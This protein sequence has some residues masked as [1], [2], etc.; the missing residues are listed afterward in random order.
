MH[1]DILLS[2]FFELLEKRRITA[3]ELSQKHGVSPRTVYR[4]VDRLSEFL[5][6]FILRGRTGGICLADNFKLPLG[7]FTAEE[8]AAAVDGLALAY[9]HIPTSAL[10]SAKRKLGA[11]EKRLRRQ[12]IWTGTKEILFLPSDDDFA[13]KLRAARD[14]IKDKRLLKL[15]YR[16]DGK[17]VEYTVEPHALVLQKEWH[18]FSFCYLHRCF[19]AFPLQ[20]IEGILRT[21]ERFRP[22][23]FDENEVIMTV[24]GVR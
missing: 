13:E 21:R 5:P 12:R 14:C 24:A 2:I 3:K 19:I 9:E 11:Q 6:L 17:K 18:L 22:R 7:F 16:I 4:Y 20:E 15:L 10:L 1:S 23:R 8:Y